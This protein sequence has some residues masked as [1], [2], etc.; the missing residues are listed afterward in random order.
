MN[1]YQEGYTVQRARSH[2]TTNVQVETKTVHWSLVSHI[3]PNVQNR[4]RKSSNGVSKTVQ[5]RI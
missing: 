1:K 4:L 5:V 3:K 2:I